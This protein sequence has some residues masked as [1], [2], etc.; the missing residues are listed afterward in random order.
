MASPGSGSACSLRLCFAALVGPSV[1]LVPV[2]AAAGAATL[3]A[4]KPAGR[5][6][7]Q[8]SARSRAAALDG[9]S[10][11]RAGL[12]SCVGFAD[13]REVSDT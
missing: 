8:I 4:A 13:I 7:A 1:L 2:L 12:R 10:T 9:H 3:A 6:V 11:A 5:P